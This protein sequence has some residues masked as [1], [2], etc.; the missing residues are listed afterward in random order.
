MGVTNNAKE[1]HHLSNQKTLVVLGY[2]GN[3]TTQLC[4]DKVPTKQPV[5]HGKYPRLFFV[6]YVNS[7]FTRRHFQHVPKERQA[8]NSFLANPCAHLGSS[9]FHHEQWL[10]S[11]KQDNT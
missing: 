10:L 3:Y 5:F 8:G 6:T 2:V 11:P 9:L 7:F 4:G 1:K